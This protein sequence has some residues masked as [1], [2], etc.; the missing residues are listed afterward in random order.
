MR[1]VGCSLQLPK[2]KNNV[3]CKTTHTRR[4]IL[5]RLLPCHC[6]VHRVCMRK[7]VTTQFPQFDMLHF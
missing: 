1:L 5:A 6:D 2:Q 7:Y 4:H 3:Q